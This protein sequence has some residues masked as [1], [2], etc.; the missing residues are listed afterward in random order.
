MTDESRAELR[1]GLEAVVRAAMDAD[2]EVRS[3]LNQP[4][5][6]SEAADP[7][8]VAG[9][10]HDVGVAVDGFGTLATLPPLTQLQH[11]ALSVLLGD[12]KVSAAVLIGALEDSGVWPAGAVTELAE[13]VRA[14]ERER[15]VKAAVQAERERCFAMADLAAA[16]MP[17]MV[18]TTLREAIYAGLKPS[19]AA[20]RL[21]RAAAPPA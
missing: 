4:W 8:A 19:Q 15:V 6:D 16:Y 14:E 18:A 7:D 12:P 20:V 5:F 10:I 21:A 3:R 13:R 17:Y 1:R 2:A 9:E 11:L